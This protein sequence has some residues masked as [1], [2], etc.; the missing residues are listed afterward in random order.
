MSLKTQR[1]QMK[2]Y[3]KNTDLKL[4]GV[5]LLCC[6]CYYSIHVPSTGLMLRRQLKRF[7]IAG[8]CDPRCVKDSLGQMSLKL[9]FDFLKICIFM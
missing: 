5:S 9:M 7:F 3:S 2:S 4:L 6:F 8:V 1:Q